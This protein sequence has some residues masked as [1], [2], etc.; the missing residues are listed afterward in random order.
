MYQKRKAFENILILGL[1][2][3]SILTSLAIAFWIRYGAIWGQNQH[4]DR[5]WLVMFMAVLYA[6]IN[7]FVDF[8]DHFF[9]RGLFEEIE[10]VVK[11]E[12]IFALSL[13][14]LLF[15]LH[16]SSELSRLIFGYFIID[17]KSVV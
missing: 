1:D 11:A 3:V 10:N 15:L 9:R 12:V 8:N 2:I 13:L 14:L 7:I 6:A 16:R 5:M 4:G 17:R